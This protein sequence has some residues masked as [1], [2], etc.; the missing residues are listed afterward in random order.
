M[1]FMSETRSKKSKLKIYNSVI[2]PVVA[3]GSETWVLK[4][5]IEEIY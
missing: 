5:Q 4:K 3:Y 2:S 1:C